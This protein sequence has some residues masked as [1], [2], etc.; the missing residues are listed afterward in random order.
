[1]PGADRAREPAGGH[2]NVSAA[3]PAG[4]RGTAW[5]CG[6]AL[7]IGAVV[8]LVIQ[9]A[10]A[11]GVLVLTL[12]LALLLTALLR[13]VADWLDRHHVP[14][15][16]ATWIVLVA[17]VAVVAAVGVFI[18]QQLASQLPALQDNLAG[19]L[20]RV[21]DF[22]VG[23][24]G[25]APRQVNQ[26][27]DAAIAQVYGG[28]GSS[29]DGGST[30]AALVNG[31]RML[32]TALAGLALALFT[33][34]W[35]VYDGDRVW[36]FLLRLCPD[37]WQHRAEAAGGAAWHTLG[38]YLR[39][40]TLIALIDGVAVGVALL[41]LGVPLPLTLGLITFLGGYVPL[42]GAT[43]AGLAAVLVA[44]AAKGVTTALLTL[45]AV[46]LVQQLEGQFLQ[47]IIMGRTLELHP[48]AIAYA[49]SLG[50]LLWGIPGAIISVPLAAACYAVGSVLANP[51][52]ERGPTT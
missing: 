50:A 5:W 2:D 21:R 48:L 34:F 38:G 16:A 12:L 41:L 49:L 3:M 43:I 25:L 36:H 31:A 46:I 40:V 11:A 47:P 14:R 45:G 7:L 39:G 24:V 29:S 20:N 13:P 8:Y 19:G 4:V 23:Q 27:V 22:L 52:A 9:F 28:S 30:G 1:V 37:R 42:V 17:A 32:L 6:A 15:L 51:V 26:L 44:L 35:L 33:A 10:V 18:E